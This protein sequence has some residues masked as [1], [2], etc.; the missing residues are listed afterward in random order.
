MAGSKSPPTGIG[1]PTVPKAA[2]GPNSYNSVAA[3]YARAKAAKDAE[4][5]AKLGGNN[6]AVQKTGKAEQSTME[7]LN[8]RK[9][10]KFQREWIWVAA[11]FCWFL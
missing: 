6:G 3:Q 8:A 4:E 7:R 1:A 2:S 10:R 5:Q 9:K 11:M